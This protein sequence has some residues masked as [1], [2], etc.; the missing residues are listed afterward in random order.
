MQAGT[1]SDRSV[2]TVA[3]REKAAADNQQ[4]T[5]VVVRW[6][7]WHAHAFLSQICSLFMMR[8]YPLL[9]PPFINY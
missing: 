9:P 3:Q 4:P 8:S 7:Q 2:T 5:I 6:G 1:L